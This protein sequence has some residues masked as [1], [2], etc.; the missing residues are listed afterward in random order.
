MESN[1]QLQTICCRISAKTYWEGE[2]TPKTFISQ[3]AVCHLAQHLNLK[4]HNFLVD[5]RLTSTPCLLLCQDRV[6][7]TANQETTR[8][9]E[10]EMTFCLLNWEGGGEIPPLEYQHG[11]VQ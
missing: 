11:M 7:Q 2:K 5:N 9:R 3:I 10:K 6:F 4:V 1:E 8:I